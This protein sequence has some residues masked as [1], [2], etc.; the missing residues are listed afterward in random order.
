MVTDQDIVTP[1]D[2]DDENDIG[3]SFSEALIL[4]STNPQS[5]VIL[6]V[7]WGKVKIADYGLTKDFTNIYKA[8][9]CMT[10]QELVLQH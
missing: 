9:D 4:A 5:V 3:K 2:E 10:S 8:E 6:W 7:N 1:Q